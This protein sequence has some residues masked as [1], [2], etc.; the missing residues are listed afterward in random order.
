MRRPLICLKCSTIC[1]S[2]QHIVHMT[3]IKSFIAHLNKVVE[4]SEPLRVLAGLHL[5]ERAQLGGGKGDV[6]LA[7]HNLQLLSTDAIGLW[8]IAIV[9]LQNLVCESRGRISGSHTL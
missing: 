4:H 2:S 5:Q 7:D 8:P 9:F 6:L 3:G 1:T